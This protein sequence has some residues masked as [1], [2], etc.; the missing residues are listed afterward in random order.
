VIR[1]A[2]LL[3]LLAL[4]L[5]AQKKPVTIDTVMQHDFAHGAE[6]API[7]APNG[8]Q[9]AFRKGDSVMLYDIPSKSEKELLSLNPLEKAAV[10]PPEEE[11]FD[12]QN[13]RVTES[14]FAW[15]KSGD[16]MLLEVQ[17]DLFLWHKS[18]GKWE[19]LT[20]TAVEEHDPKLSPNGMAV[21]FRRGHDLYSMNI[22][23]R[24]WYGSPTME[25]RPC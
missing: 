11:R 4:T 22:A 8:K 24:R 21:A 19:Q 12:W 1:I 3:F 14:S 2:A 16:E 5:L 10:R 6:G 15:S 7:W 20:S 9:F 23:S 17:G 18:T 25:S 13:R